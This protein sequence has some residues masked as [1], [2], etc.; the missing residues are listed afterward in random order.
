M[1]V[2]V[3]AFVE[4]FFEFFQIYIFLVTVKNRKNLIG[5]TI[6]QDNFYYLGENKGKA[7]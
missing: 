4:S 2:G 1:E 6:V 3:Q 7:S 5:N